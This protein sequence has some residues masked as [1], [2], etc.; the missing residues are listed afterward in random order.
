MGCCLLIKSPQPSTKIDPRI[1]INL[2]VRLLQGGLVTP[3]CK[4]SSDRGYYRC[5]EKATDIIDVVHK[6]GWK[7]HAF[8]F[9][10]EYMK[11]Y[12]DHGQDPYR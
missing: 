10:N 5:N 3:G 1:A 2:Q 7:A 8:T 11:L 6:H 12:W 9:R 4:D